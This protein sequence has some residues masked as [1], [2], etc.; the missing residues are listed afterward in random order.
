MIL[1][2]MVVLKA[3]NLKFADLN[4]KQK[5]RIAADQILVAA[6]EERKVDIRFVFNF[7]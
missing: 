7:G 1:F 3:N 5:E 4:E 6:K 2:V